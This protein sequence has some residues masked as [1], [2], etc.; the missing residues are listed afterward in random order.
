M[1]KENSKIQHLLDECRKYQA[2]I[3]LVLA[4]ISTNKRLEN[5]DTVV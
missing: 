1:K 2:E 4:T 3:N 5:I